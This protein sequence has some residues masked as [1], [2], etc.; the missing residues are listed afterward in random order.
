VGA[1]R[2]TKRVAADG[3]PGI[4]VEDRKSSRERNFGV[5][6][7][8]DSEDLRFDGCRGEEGMAVALS[9]DILGYDT[10]AQTGSAV[11][12]Q[13]TPNG[14]ARCGSRALAAWSENPTRAEIFLVW[15]ELVW[16]DAVDIGRPTPLT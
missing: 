4:R 15:C 11:G 7:G 16:P 10:V 6:P 1:A 13:A 8:P 5:I 14:P 9:L 12:G 2:V 3:D